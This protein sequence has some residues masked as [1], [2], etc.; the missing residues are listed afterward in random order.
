[1]KSEGPH[2]S[3]AWI[4]LLALGLAMSAIGIFILAEYHPTVYGCGFNENR[5]QSEECLDAETYE[6]IGIVITVAGFIVFVTCGIIILFTKDTVI[7]TCPRCQMS[8]IGT[9]RGSNV[10][11]PDID[12]SRTYLLSFQKPQYTYPSNARRNRP[13]KM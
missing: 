1:M 9:S 6:S 8:K 5:S 11:I 2:A 7:F 10:Y 12:G 13:M 3:I 4:I